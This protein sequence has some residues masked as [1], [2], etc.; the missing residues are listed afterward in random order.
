MSEG[1]FRVRVHG[2]EG[3]GT[4]TAARLLAAAAVRDGMSA[5]ALE[6]FGRERDGAPVEAFCRIGGGRPVSSPPDVEA[7]AVIVQD[8][9]LV[10]HAHVLRSLS[11]EAYVLVNARTVEH[12]GLG[13]LIRGLPDGHVVAVEATSHRFPNAALLGALVGITGAV[14]LESLNAAMRERFHDLAAG[15]SVVAATQA[16]ATFA[17]TA[18]VPG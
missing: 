3:Q 7:D 10:R 4:T 15:P 18:V 16:Y 14:T 8:A 2:R 17:R 9:T 5:E 13:G 1:P 11:P 12:L 6:C